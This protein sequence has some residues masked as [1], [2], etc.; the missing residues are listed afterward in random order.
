MQHHL[1]SN[2]VSYKPVFDVLSHLHILSV[3]FS[4]QQTKA[5]IWRKYTNIHANTN[6]ECN[7][8]LTSNT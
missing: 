5:S 8:G 6:A 1:H 7:T 3:K 4:T 2:A